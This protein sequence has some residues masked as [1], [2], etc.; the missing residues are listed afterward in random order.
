[1]ALSWNDF[2]GGT[3]VPVQP[4]V[5]P[6]QAIYDLIDRVSGEYGVNPKLIR[7]MVKQES[8]FNPK[9]VSPAGA[10]GLMQLMPLTAGEMGVKDPFDPEQ[11]IRGGVGYYK[12]MLDAQGGDQARALA[13]YNFGPGN[14]AKG[15]EWPKE[16]RDYIAAVTGSG[17]GDA[18]LHNVTKQSSLRWNDFTPPSDGPGL[19][20]KAKTFGGM[21]KDSLVESTT[22][23]VPTGKLPLGIPS[24]PNELVQSGLDVAYGIPEALASLGSGM[25]SFPAGQ[26]GGLAAL[27]RD[28]KSLAKAFDI[29]ESVN[30]AGMYKPVTN[31]GQLLL[32]PIETAFGAF[33]GTVDKIARASAPEGATEEE[34]VDRSKAWQYVANT[35]LLGAPL[36]VKGSRVA[37]RK[38][39]KGKAQVT[40]EVLESAKAKVM[41]DPSI[42]PAVKQHVASTPLDKIAEQIN[43]GQATSL[44]EKTGGPQVKFEGNGDIVKGLL[45]EAELREGR[46]KVAMRKA[47]K[48]VAEHDGDISTADL[49]GIN[50]IDPKGSTGK[51]IARL[52]AERDEARKMSEGTGEVPEFS[53]PPVAEATPPAT[54]VSS[55]PPVGVRS[56]KPKAKVADPVKIAAEVDPQIEAHPEQSLGLNWWTDKE[57]TSTFATKTLDP[58]E[59][60][61]KLEEIRNGYK[62]KAA[63]SEVVPDVIDISKASESQIKEW[64]DW[65]DAAGVV[66]KGVDSIISGERKVGMAFPNQ[67]KEIGEAKDAGLYTKETADGAI[68]YGKRREVNKLVKDIDEGLVDPELSKKLGYTQAEWDNMI[69]HSWENFVKSKNEK[70]AWDILNELPEYIEREKLYAERSKMSEVEFSKRDATY[71]AR[72][73]EINNKIDE[74]GDKIHNSEERKAWSAEYDAQENV[75]KVKELER[76]KVRDLENRDKWDSAPTHGTDIDKLPGILS[77]GLNTGSALD[78][79]PTRE[80]SSEYPIQVIVPSAIKGS[81]IEHNDY[82]KSGNTARAARVEIDLEQYIEPEKIRVSI[83]ELQKQYPDVEFRFKEEPS[84]SDTIIS[85]FDNIGFAK[86]EGYTFPSKRTYGT[87]EEATTVAN[88]K[89][90]GYEVVKVGEK[91]RVG[92]YVEEA[93]RGEYVPEVGD[94]GEAR[95]VFELA[96]EEEAKKSGDWDI[97]R[98]TKEID[99]MQASIDMLR[100][101]EP[102]AHYNRVKSASG[103]EVGQV[104]GPFT[105]DNAINQLQLDVMDKFEKIEEIKNSK[106]A[107]KSEVDELYSDGVTV[108]D[109]KVL[110]EITKGVNLEEIRL[111][112]EVVAEIKTAKE[113]IPPEAKGTPIDSASAA[114]KFLEWRDSYVTKCNIEDTVPVKGKKKGSKKPI[115]KEALPLVDDKFAIFDNL[116]DAEAFRDAK[117][118]SQEIIRDP[119]TGKYFLEPELDLLDKG[120]MWDLGDKEYLEETYSRDGG[121]GEDSIDYGDSGGR[122]R[123]LWD[124]MNN[125]RG[126]VDVTPLYGAV[127]TIENVVK[128]AKKVGKTVDE[129]LDSMGVDQASIDLFKASLANLG[130]MKQELRDKDS[131]GMK[132]LD[133]LGPI[134]HQTIKKDKNG[135]VVWTRPPVT[136]ELAEGVVGMDRRSNWG[137]DVARTDPKTGRVTV[138]HTTNILDRFMTATETKVNAFRGPIRDLYRTWRDAKA[139]AKV[140]KAEVKMWLDGLKAQ[141]APERRRDFS[142]ACYAD[143]KSV[144][145]AYEKMGITDIPTLTPAEALVKEQLLD[146]TRKFRERSNLIRTRTGQKAIPKLLDMNGQ[147]NYLPLF[148]DLNV[149]RELG[150]GEGM[151]NSTNAKLG[152]LSKTFNG[153]FNPH[154]KK[155]N[156]SDIPIELDP[157]KAIEKYSGYGLDEIHVSPV[158]AL[159]KELAYVKLPHPSGKGKVTLREWNPALSLMLSKWSDSI[160]GKDSTAT[161]MANTNPLIHKGLESLSKNLVL[162]TIGGSLRTIFVQPSS[163]VIAVPTLLDTRSTL[164]G[165]G[166]LVADRAFGREATLAKKKSSVLAIREFDLAYSE[167]TD[168]V[169]RGLATGLKDWVGDKSMAPMKWVDGVV[170]EASWNAGYHYGK[171]RLKLSGDDLVHFADDVVEK[172]QGMGIKG[173]VSDIQTGKVTKWLTLLQ[174]FGIADFNFIIRDVLGIKNADVGNKQAL[175]RA[176]KYI[177]ATVLAGQLYKMMGYENVVPDPIGEYLKVKKEGGNVHAVASA[178]GELLEKVPMIGGSAKYGSSLGGVVGE[179][180]S[181]VP[182]AAMKF[183]ESLDWDKLTPREKRKNIQLIAKAIG[184]TYGVPMTNQI[185]KSINAAYNGGNPYEVIMGVYKEAPKGGGGRSGRRGRGSSR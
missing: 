66:Y 174:T 170:A 115:T 41:A 80:W 35:A 29:A 85:E 127:E 149:L 54:P 164:Y 133:P 61:A 19:L 137:T 13:A 89:G 26:V 1:M 175:M 124:I 18:M 77:D 63:E 114:Q 27:P 150:L 87:P 14:V 107:S 72:L 102:D 47:A 30:Q 135:K 118:S 129:Y 5:D 42:P 144:R 181:L 78:Y 64:K 106:K 153:M 2:S 111:E 3:V 147:E 130:Q 10:Q 167:W 99:D 12:K 20:D 90:E 6:N 166:R 23:V 168:Y 105:R 143:M 163:Y 69:E 53:V 21:V 25:A 159:A 95:R 45:V 148:R 17:G 183:S 97:T 98:L 139:N 71:D 108:E 4:A 88:L 91:W 38:V 57:T 113:S 109:W 154:S 56:S 173:G 60:K 59:V 32:K 177:V 46:G 122:G 81:R 132:I 120:D 116:P 155:R 73:K 128:M 165:L 125:E 180:A 65:K 104:K 146:Y 117:G 37:A 83:E 134:V 179:W 161:A 184:Y 121:L 86:E 94:S 43:K 16:T 142:I 160:V 152:Q 92:K 176:S 31:T 156:V 22:P 100:T 84:T 36:A 185:M 169:Q 9:A 112:G 140:E 131:L 75:K 44:V 11:N 24:H 51:A 67:I 101:I 79:T 15:L 52:V 136:K 138:E 70:S 157:F 151:I 162:A 119:S 93:P 182:E 48:I 158:A 33:L 103:L 62:P 171:E 8:G 145:E 76:Q 141:I 34:L 40:P 172:T 7:S 96:K 55:R 123:D 49:K 110:E 82:V 178:A 126:S 68:V 74:L 58:I 28:E 39:M 50:G